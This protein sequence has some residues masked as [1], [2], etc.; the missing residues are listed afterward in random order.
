MVKI[1]AA[2]VARVTMVAKHAQMY[3]DSW[4]KTTKTKPENVIT[5]EKVE[6]FIVFKLKY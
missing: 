2:L 6:S 4:R 3:T 5:T 1:C